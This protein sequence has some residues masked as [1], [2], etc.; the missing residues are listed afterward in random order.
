MLSSCWKR[1]ITT[2]PRAGPQMLPSPPST[3]TRTEATHPRHRMEEDDPHSAEGRPP[4]AAEP[5]QH[6]HQD[7]EAVRTEVHRRRA[8]QLV[9]EDVQDA[10]DAGEEDRDDPGQVAVQAGPVAERGQPRLVGAETPQ[11]QPERGTRDRPQEDPAD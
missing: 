6:D 2:A 1:T 4:D 8:D 3:T 5:P 7:E 9:D 11:G 10:S